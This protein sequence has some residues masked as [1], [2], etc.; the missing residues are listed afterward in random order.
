MTKRVL[1]LNLKR[2]YFEQIR[3]SA[4][5]EEYRLVTPYWSKR[6][7]RQSYDEIHIMMGYPKKGDTSRT[8]VRAWWGVKV[9]TIT[10]PH[11]GGRPVQVFAIDVT[12]RVKS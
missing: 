12:R 6:L 1:N 4:K 10:H 3:D 2:E 11:F 5:T 8:I 7:A 9:K